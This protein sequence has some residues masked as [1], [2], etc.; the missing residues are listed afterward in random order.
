VAGLARGARIF[1]VHDVRTARHALDVAWSI[2]RREA[3]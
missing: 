3:A 1:R 2:L